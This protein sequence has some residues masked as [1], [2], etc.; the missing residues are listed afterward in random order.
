[1]FI[2]LNRT[3]F[4]GLFR[5]NAKGR[6]NVP[7]GRY[8]NP[9][10]IDREKLLQAAAALSGRRVRLVWGSFETARDVAAAGDFV[11][12]DP[13]YAP[14]SRTANFTSYTA[15]RF[16]GADQARLQHFAIELARRG[17]HVL[18]SNSTAAEIRALYET[19]RDARAAG[20]RSIRVPARRAI[21]SNAT[22]RG[23]VE[24]YLISNVGVVA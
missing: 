12:C 19:N 4:N 23:A 17:C 8:T 11:Y 9:A 13:P 18:V 7:A 5:L 10:I 14:V 21:N 6:F 16:D 24:E 20:L 2:Y 1:M 3:G 15:S 22:R